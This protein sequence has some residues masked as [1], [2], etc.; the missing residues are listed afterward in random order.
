MNSHWPHSFPTGLTT[1]QVVRL[2]RENVRSNLAYIVIGMLVLLVAAVV[3]LA[4][5]KGAGDDT[6]LVIAGVL[7]PVI[8]IAGTV[9][10]FYFGAETQKSS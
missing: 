7:T 5:W 4:A 2:R 9:L 3:T 1:G 10:G 6:K 8:G